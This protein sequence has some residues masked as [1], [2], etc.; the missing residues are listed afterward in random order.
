MED[1]IAA[2]AT[3]YGEGGI[4]IIRISGEDALLILNKVFQPMR[5][6]INNSVITDKYEPD[7]VGVTIGESIVNRRLTYGHIIDYSTNQVLDEVLAVYMKAPY[8]YTKEDVVEIN[9]HGSIVSLRKVLELVLR[10]GARMAEPGEFTK[11]AFLNGRLDLTQAEAVID[12]IKAKSDKSFDVA[13]GQLEG[14]LS[15]VIEQIR[16]LLMDEL[17]N[18]TVNIDYPDEDIEEITYDK[19]LNNL[20][21]IDDMIQNLIRSADTGRI[22][23]EGFKVAIVGKPNVGKSSLMNALLKENRAIV[24]DIPGTTRDTIVE[25]ITIKKIPVKLIDTAGIHD[26]DDKVEKIG[27]EKS[28][29][30]FNEADLVIL[31][32]DGSQAL[33]IEDEN[34]MNVIGNR[35]T[36]VLINKIDLGQVLNEK[37]LQE[38]MPKALFIKTA[39]KNGQGINEIE[40]KIEDL[41][42]NGEVKQSGSTFITN[43]R[44]ANL[45]NSAK[46]ALDDAIN[47]VRSG[48]ALEFIEIDVKRTFEFLGEIIGETVSESII[49]EVFSRFCLGK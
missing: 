38:K 4:G 8:T 2:V 46:T 40:N 6:H 19:L 13:L 14:T 22:I 36:L 33:S 15:D 45:L 16:N 18:I 17:V 20:L 12:L 41:V 28:K 29:A 30:T 44:H 3:A 1:T 48:E 32:L 9:C 27:I 39:V 24:T 42:F 26:T 35:R 31:I 25:D 43:V 5:K 11:R 23:K 34:I 21:Q 47:M 49:D 7:S 37:K 10:S